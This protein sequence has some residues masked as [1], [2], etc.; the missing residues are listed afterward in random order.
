MHRLSTPLLRSIVI[1]P[2]GGFLIDA[3]AAAAAVGANIIALCLKLSLHATFLLPAVNV[4]VYASSR[5]VMG[6]VI[7]YSDCHRRQALCSLTTVACC[8]H[9]TAGLAT[10]RPL[11]PLS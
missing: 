5:D 11:P 9:P 4:R 7:D 10:L 1:D 6:C 3:V 8:V 2:G